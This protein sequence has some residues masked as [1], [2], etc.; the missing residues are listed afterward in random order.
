MSAYIGFDPDG[1]QPA[2]RAAC[3]P[4][5][6]LVHLQ[7]HGH[8]PV[9][10][11]GGGTGMIGDPSGKT[12]ERQLLD[13][14]A[15][16]GR[17]RRASARS[18]SGSSTSRARA[19]RGCATTPSG[20][21]S[22]RLVE[23]LRDMGKHFTVNY[24][25]QKESV[26]SRMDAGIS[27]T[28][29]AYMLLQ[30]YDFLEL[31]RRDG[32]MLQL[33]GSDQW[34]N[35]TAGIELIRR[36]DG[37]EAHGL[38]VP[39]VTTSAGTKFGKTEAGAVWLDAERTS[40]YAFYQFW[41]GT[42][43]ADVGRYLR[44]FTLLDA[45]RDRGAGCGDGAAPEKRAAQQALARDVTRRV[46][47]DA[48]LAAAEQVSTFFFGGLDPREL[49]PEA[50]AHP[51]RRGALR[52]GGRD[53][54]DAQTATSRRLDVLKLLTASGLAASNGAAK[55]L[56]EQGGVSVNKRK[57]ACSR[58]PGESL[59][60]PCCAGGYVVVGKGKR[61]LRQCIRQSRWQQLPRARCTGPVAIR[62]VCVAVRREADGAF[63]NASA[64]YARVVQAR[65]LIGAGVGRGG[66]DA[67][68]AM[69][70][71]RRHERHAALTS[72]GIEH[73]RV[74]WRMCAER[75]PGPSSCSS[76]R[77]A[78][79]P[80]KSWNGSVICSKRRASS[81]QRQVVVEQATRSRRSRA[82][83]SSSPAAAR[84]RDELAAH[85]G[86][87]GPPRREQPL[88][89]AAGQDVDAGAMDVERERPESLD[90]VD[91]E[92]HAARAA[93]SAEPV[94]IGDDAGGE[95]DP[96][97]REHAHARA[98]RARRAARPR[99]AGRRAPARGAA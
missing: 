21:T 12:T 73:R 78:S 8:R 60:T 25:L 11:V 55:R 59:A 82:R 76:S 87:A 3:V 29:F 85:V 15:G 30:A 84:A 2:R 93:G 17:T 18:S 48:A 41:L 94:E 56:L 20:C 54:R 72:R 13:A 4:I 1:E 71:A 39:L 74:R 31:R 86:E 75:H 38:T 83:P 62:R 37:V 33:G 43:D 26:R 52:R 61:E 42:E 49:T 22:L 96:R 23:F 10:L 97:E 27:F 16:G 7:R 70:G 81:R 68:P 45:R 46:H 36:V 35:I 80:A 53:G 63:A 92:V 40:P 5:M 69:A 64:R 88:L 47:G 66:R 90:G 24:M 79:M 51:A 77:L 89:R 19:R 6:I 44:Y 14:R 50:F 32:V 91:D 9:A 65:A 58:P 98:R 34:G 28:E 57:L 95:A 99:R 67:M